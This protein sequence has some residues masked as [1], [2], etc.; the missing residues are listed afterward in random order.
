MWPVVHALLVFLRT[1]FRSRLSVQVEVLAL[2]H[3]LAVYQQGSPRT[4]PEHFFG[5][6]SLGLTPRPE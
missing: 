2:R 3:Q 1:L 4:D 5:Q 6:S